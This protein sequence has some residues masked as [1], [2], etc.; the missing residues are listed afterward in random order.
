MIANGL[1]AEAGATGTREARA[2]AEALERIAETP[3][4]VG[5]AVALTQTGDER[6][7]SPAVDGV[8]A[9]ERGLGVVLGASGETTFEPS[10]RLMRIAIQS[11]AARWSRMLPQHSHRL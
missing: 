7:G 4:R 11:S 6:V 3:V 8:P 10:K 5:E 9:L 1:E 2:S